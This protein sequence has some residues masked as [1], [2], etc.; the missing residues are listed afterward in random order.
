LNFI[1]SSRFV[2]EIGD[3]AGD[4]Y[5]RAAYSNGMYSPVVKPS[6]IVK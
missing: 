3:I 1:R 5:K 4:L 2:D 6:Y